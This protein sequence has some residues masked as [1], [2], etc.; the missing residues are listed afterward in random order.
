MKGSFSDR[1]EGAEK[2]GLDYVEQGVETEWSSI[3]NRPFDAAAEFI[4]GIGTTLL[5]GPEAVPGTEAV[6]AGSI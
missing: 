1:I 2:E 6:I 5:F 3:K 4:G